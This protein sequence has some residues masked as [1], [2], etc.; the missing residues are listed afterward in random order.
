[1]TEHRAPYGAEKPAE[2]L[3]EIGCEFWRDRQC[4]YDLLPL[5]HVASGK[6]SGTY[7]VKCPLCEQWMLVTVEYKTLVVATKA[8][9]MP[10]AG[11]G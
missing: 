6:R 9:M 8:S 3:K 10:E 4:N 1:M 5:V 7:R 2:P 11:A